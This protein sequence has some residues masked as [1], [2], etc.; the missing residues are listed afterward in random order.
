[1]LFWLSDCNNVPFSQGHVLDAPGV[2]DDW[3]R[4]CN[5]TLSLVI[6]YGERGEDVRDLA[7]SLCVVIMHHPNRVI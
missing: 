7:L 1:M 2:T 5:T 3:Y 6:V 4:E